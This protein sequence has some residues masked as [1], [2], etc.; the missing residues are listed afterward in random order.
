MEQTKVQNV[1]KTSQKKSQFS[2]VRV[3][4][5]TQKKLSQLLLKANKKT[6]R[7]RVKADQLLSLSLSLLNDVHIKNLQ[8]GSLSNTDKL[9]MRFKDYVK[10][11]GSI[12]KDEF[13]GKLLEQSIKSD[14]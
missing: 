5:S 14:A 10:K 1:I 8:E 13:L 4:S 9:E 12:S 7:K 6:F 2:A 11:N 3:S